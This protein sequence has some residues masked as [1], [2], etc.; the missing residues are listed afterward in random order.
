MLIYDALKND[1]DKV[2]GLLN[3][4]VQLSDDEKEDRHELIE[5]IRDELIPHSRAEEAV[6]YNT[7]RSL[8]AAR[9]VA[10]HGYQEHLEAETF[11]RMLQVRDKI[12][13]EWKST[14]EKLRNA[15]L[16]HIK[17]EEGK[18]FNVAQQCFTN[19]EARMMAEAFEKLKPE[20][21][22]EGFVKTTIELVANM[23]PPRFSSVFGRANLESRL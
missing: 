5:Q 23:M 18:I 3:E 1:H 6:F 11:L 20:L 9:D 16:H 13:A 4:L 22:A 15:L 21:Q 7:L 19:D 14:A 10:M 2:K 12:D 8:D 17:E